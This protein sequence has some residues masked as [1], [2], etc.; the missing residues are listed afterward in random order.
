MPFPIKEKFIYRIYLQISV[1]N[2]CE[3]KFI[4]PPTIKEVIDDFEIKEVPKATT[5][6]WTTTLKAVRSSRPRQSHS[7]QEQ[8]AVIENPSQQENNEEIEEITP[9]E[10]TKQI[11]VLFNKVKHEVSLHFST[12][13]R[14]YVISISVVISVIILTIIVRCCCKH[15]HVICVYFYKNCYASTP[16]NLNANN[17]NNVEPPNWFMRTFS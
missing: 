10:A 15:R 4:N 8:P 2:N 7:Q 5:T 1:S 3:L 13:F 17:D 9:F 14:I 6:P 16:N 12:H 11:H